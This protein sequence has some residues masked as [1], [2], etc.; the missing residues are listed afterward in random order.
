LNVPTSTVM[1]NAVLVEWMFAASLIPRYEC[2]F[3]LEMARGHNHDGTLDFSLVYRGRDTQF[4]VEGL[5]SGVEYLFRCRALSPVGIS[6]WSR[7]KGITTERIQ[8][9]TKGPNCKVSS[10]GL[11]AEKLCTSQP[12]WNATIVGKLPL[13]PGLLHKWSIEIRNSAKSNIFIGVAPLSIDRNSEENG[14]SCGYYMFLQ[15]GSLYSGPPYNA[16]G[17]NY[18]NNIIPAGSVVGVILDLSRGLLGFTVHGRYIGLAFINLPT[19]QPL[20]PVVILH[21]PGDSVVFHKIEI[22]SQHNHLF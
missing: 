14:I 6:A 13:L 19:N 12:G 2:E 5:D 4:Y 3:E 10:D 18:A 21:D 7:T 17:Y 20:V 8:R 9:F 22:F 11:T 16:R 15:N 1:P